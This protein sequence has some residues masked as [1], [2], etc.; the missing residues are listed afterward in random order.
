MSWEDRS[1]DEIKLF[2]ESLERV[3]GG[4]RVIKK[5]GLYEILEKKIR[6]QED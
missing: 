1:I 5:L 3:L 2:I 6:E 4:R